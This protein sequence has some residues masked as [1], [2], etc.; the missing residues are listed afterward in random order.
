V[1]LRLVPLGADADTGEL[2]ARLAPGFGGDPSGAR[3]ILVQTVEFLAREPRPD[4]WG[5]YLAYAGETAV[6]TGAFKSAP[7]E[8]GTV[9]IAYMTFPAFE[10]K[11]H[12]RA[13]VPALTSMALEHG[14]LLVVAHTLPEENASNRALRSSGF[15]FAGEVSDPEDGLIWRWEKS[16]SASAGESSRER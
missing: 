10:G 12:A 4:P 5:S 13:M 7:D 14:A 16:S 11:G 2:A 15:A 3:E 6:A 9:E 1:T 8:A